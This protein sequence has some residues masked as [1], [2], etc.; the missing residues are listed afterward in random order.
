[1]SRFDVR[2]QVP[3]ASKAVLDVD[4][5]TLEVAGDGNAVTVDLSTVLHHLK[6][7]DRL[8]R[9]DTPDGPVRL[10][11]Y[12]GAYSGV[13]E[14][15]HSGRWTTDV[16]R[17]SP[18]GIGTRVAWFDTPREAAVFRAKWDAKRLR[19]RS[20]S[21]GTGTDVSAHKVPK[22]APETSGPS[23]AGDASTSMPPPTSAP[24]VESQASAHKPENVSE[25]DDV[26][27]VRTRTADERNREGFESAV[28]IE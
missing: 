25:D 12:S 9:V 14:C 20:S 24:P 21:H 11:V 19:G 1:M 15:P 16:S 26:Q 22:A 17:A 23:S 28:L 27:I 7:L 13:R 4:S 10:K 18:E 5:L 6:A 3:G 2:S 8:H